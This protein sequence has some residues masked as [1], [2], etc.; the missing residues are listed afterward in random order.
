METPFTTRLEGAPPD[1]ALALLG[2]LDI[3]GTPSFEVGLAELL[4]VAPPVPVVDLSGLTFLG[5]A[6][7]GAII[8][9]QRVHPDLVLRGVRPAQ[10]RV[11]EVAGV[12][13]VLRLEPEPVAI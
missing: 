2:E 1:V 8:R 13:P 10:R 4:E 9:A 7:L 3:D 11:F 5:S 12:L 6:G